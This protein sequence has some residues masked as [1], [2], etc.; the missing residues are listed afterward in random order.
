MDLSNSSFIISTLSG[1]KVVDPQSLLEYKNINLFGN[2]YYEWGKV[3]NQNIANLAD[4]VA[5]LEDGGV[6]QATFDANQFIAQFQNAQTTALNEHTTNLLQAIDIKF[7]QEILE[8]NSGFSD[9]LNDLETKVTQL[10][11]AYIT[12]DTTLESKIK[13]DLNLVIDA[14]KIEVE[15]V[16]N[17]NKLIFDTFKNDII[18]WKLSIDPKVSVFSDNFNLFKEETAASF[19]NLENTTTT[20]INEIVANLEVVSNNVLNVNDYVLEL[21]KQYVDAEIDKVELT[22][23]DYKN[24]HDENIVTIF[25]DLDG[26][27]TTV[28]AISNKLPTFITTT[29]TILA[30]AKSY[31]DTQISNL[32]GTTG[33]LTTLTTNFNNFKT[34]TEN[35][36]TTLT[37]GQSTLTT[38]LGTLNTNFNDFKTSTETSITTLNNTVNTNNNNIVARLDIIETTYEPNWKSYTDTAIETLENNLSVLSTSNGDSTLAIELINEDITNIETEISTIKSNIT[39]NTNDITTINSTLSDLGS[40]SEL[41]SSITTTETNAKAYTDTRETSI[42]SAYQNADTNNLTL[43]KN[44]TDNAISVLESTIPGSD[45][46]DFLKGENNLRINEI[47]AINITS[48][49]IIQTQTEI[50]LQLSN[51]GSSLDNKI[52]NLSNSI[53]QNFEYSKENFVAFDT[54]FPILKKVFGYVLENRITKTDSDQ[55]FDNI[56][57]MFKDES[58]EQG[59]SNILVSLYIDTNNYI[60]NIYYLKEQYTSITQGNFIDTNNNISFT[61]LSNIGIF[62]S[63][64]NNLW[65]KQ[66]T[67]PKEFNLN[68]GK[69]TTL[70]KNEFSFEYQ[71]DLQLSNIII[72]NELKNNISFYKAKFLTDPSIFTFSI[73]INYNTSF[74]LE[75]I[76][77]INNGEEV[78]ANS[79]SLTLSTERINTSTTNGTIKQK[80]LDIVLPDMAVDDVTQLIPESFVNS[81]YNN[82]RIVGTMNGAP[83]ETNINISDYLIFLI[84]A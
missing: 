55:L 9:N 35:N 81:D 50:E 40:I 52:N 58:I 64:P 44:Y 22:I 84:A 34:S 78:L 27:V 76:I 23:L 19:L 66:I 39:T 33:S 14:N 56:M 25:S 38:N 68:T 51:T 43:A 74:V 2:G 54:I 72:L 3:L 10:E 82:I 21:S 17:N 46:I 47:N 48:A 63:K 60:I 83:F 42:V 6:Q 31:T 11:S 37:T 4:K 30:D 24:T 59:Y 5:N 45:D 20:K 70:Y 41:K 49:Q 12:A 28:D 73:L 77:Y 1:N 18:L 53:V 7:D 16:V 75:K 8:F 26:L 80:T 62:D 15:S 57:L 65:F 69:L 29:N 61:S 32:T 71:I 36:I 67:I 13:N 79:S